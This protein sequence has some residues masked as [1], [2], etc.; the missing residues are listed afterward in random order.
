MSLPAFLTAVALL[1]SCQEHRQDVPA[2]PAAQAPREASGPEQSV[3]LA[4]GC[5]WC[6]EAVFEEVDG[7]H[8]VTSG[9]AGGTAESAHYDQ[10]SRGITDHAEVIEVRFDPN[11]L[12]L[13]QVFEVFFR[14]AHNPT[15]LNYQGPDRGR[16]YRSAVFYSD[17]AQKSAAQAFIENLERAEAYDDPVVTTLEPLKAFHPAEDYHQDFVRKNP[18]HSYVV[19]NALPKVAKLKKLHPELLP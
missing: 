9:Y 10:V 1:A 8:S 14:V 18:R 11:V 7:V 3:V 6:T 19:Q 4:G 16:Q 15:Q 12:D 13:E 2:V 5:F 17:E